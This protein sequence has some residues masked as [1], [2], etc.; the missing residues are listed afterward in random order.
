[1]DSLDATG[2]E[3]NAPD[4]YRSSKHVPIRNIWLLMLYASSLF[5]SKEWERLGLEDLPEDLPDLIAEMLVVAVEQR[6]RRNLNKDYVAK[7]EILSRVRGRIDALVTE[8]HHLMQR[9]KVC[10]RYQQH[11]VNTPRN[12]L[13][14]CALQTISRLVTSKELG[15]R[16]RQCAADMI[17]RGVEPNRPTPA[18]IG[19]DQFSRNDADDK[20]MVDAATLA[21]DMALPTQELGAKSFS[22]ISRDEM[23]VRKLFEKAVGGFYRVT[24]K[25]LGWRVEA[26]QE[27][28]WHETEP[29]PLMQKL[30]PAMQTDIILQQGLRRIIID[31]KFT[32]LTTSSLHR[33]EIL[34][35]GYLYQLYTYVRTQEDLGD[36]CAQSAEGLLIH[37]CVGAS[38]NEHCIISGHKI[39]V[40]T[41]DLTASTSIVRE[42]L[43]K[44]ISVG[45]Q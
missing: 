45:A 5:Q 12:R 32:S 4:L 40:A 30:L 37:P 27:L 16:C 21:L 20:P 36:P 41:V 35:S 18:E 19:K 6:L 14:V 44:A 38:Y 3:A 1:M 2:M 29:S 34:K 17:A 33:S 24:L 43:L 25:P 9:A 7:T 39:A 28:R 13:V 15:R 31:T 22:K 8:S 26:G 11:T 10:C 42:Q 23:W